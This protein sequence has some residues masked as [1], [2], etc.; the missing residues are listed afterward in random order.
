MATSTNYCVS[1]YKKLLCKAIG[2]HVKQY[3]TDTECSDATKQR[4][5]TAFTI[6]SSMRQN[7][8]EYLFK[9][10]LENAKKGIDS[11]IKEK[12]KDM[13]VTNINFS[14]EAT[15]RELDGASCYALDQTFDEYKLTF[16]I[17]STNKPIGAKL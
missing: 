11:T 6:L 5:G 7:E 16:T 2:D 15:E 12:Y 14:V 8:Y 3:I 4:Y 10:F 13:I 17:E 9:S 1:D